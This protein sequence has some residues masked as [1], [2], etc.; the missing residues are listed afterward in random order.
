[1][2]DLEILEIRHSEEY[3]QYI[4]ALCRWASRFVPRIRAQ[5]A[6]QA[7]DKYQDETT[8]RVVLAY[9]EEAQKL[10]KS[11]LLDFDFISE[12][13]EWETAETALEDF[14]LNNAGKYGATLALLFNIA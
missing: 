13:P 3:K 1:M 12:H 9:G 10:D 2:T 11:R 8:R 7:F 6:R 5:Y 14:S 4:A